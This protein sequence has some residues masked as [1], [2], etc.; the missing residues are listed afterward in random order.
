[1]G[2]THTPPLHPPLFFVQLVYVFVQRFIPSS[3]YTTSSRDENAMKKKVRWQLRN[4]QW[5]LSTFYTAFPPFCCLFGLWP[6]IFSSFLITMRFLSLV[7]QV[8]SPLHQVL[9]HFPHHH[10]VLISLDK[11]NATRLEARFDHSK[12]MPFMFPI[13]TKLPH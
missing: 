12:I 1:M 4:L 8:P 5:R 6:V 7:I 3:I 11:H 10:H 2:G 9:D 13:H